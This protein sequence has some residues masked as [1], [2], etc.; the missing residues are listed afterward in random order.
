MFV[1]LSHTN[2]G[3]LVSSVNSNSLLGHV[4]SL[5]PGLVEVANAISFVGTVNPVN[6]TDFS[7]VRR[8]ASSIWS[9]GTF[10]KVL[11]DDVAVAVVTFGLV[12]R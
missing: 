10:S 3:V 4:S 12:V 2:F 11:G 9:L 6:S 1:I 5:I 7:L 8:N